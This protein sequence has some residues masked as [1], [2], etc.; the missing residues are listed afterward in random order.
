VIKLIEVSSI[1]KAQLT[2][3][4]LPSSDDNTPASQLIY[5]VYV[6]EQADFIPEPSLLKAELTG[7]VN[8]QIKGLKAGQDY[9]VLI[10]ATDKDG[11]QSYSNLL[12]G[13][14]IAINA[15]RTNS[16][17]HELGISNSVRNTGD[18]LV[19]RNNGGILRKIGKTGNTTPAALNEIFSDLSLATTIKLQDIPE[20][21]NTTQ[22]KLSAR[23][24]NTTSSITWQESG[25]TLKESIINSAISN[26]A[27]STING[28]LRTIN[29]QYG[30]IIA[31]SYAS[32]QAGIAFNLTAQLNA[33]HDKNTLLGGYQHIEFCRAELVSFTHKKAA[34]NNLPKPSS[35][36]SRGAVNNAGF[37]DK[38]SLSLNWNP[39]TA[40]I[41]LAGLPYIATIKAYFDVVGDNCNGDN[42]FGTWEDTPST[43]IPVYVIQGTPNS[44]A[45]NTKLSFKGDFKVDDSI[46]YD[47]QPELIINATLNR[48]S[49]ASADL[50][51]KADLSFANQL[52]INA[53]AA[54][55][56]SQ[57]L[58]VIPDKTFVKVF[59]AGNVPIVVSGTFKMNAQLDGNISGKANL[60]KLLQLNLPNTQFGLQYRNGV[61]SE[62][63]NIKANYVFNISGDGNANADMTLTL[64]PDL[65]ISFYDAAT[66]RLIAKPYAYA[67]AGMQGILRYLD[68]NGTALTDLNYWFTD[69]QAGGG[70]TA[71]LYAGLH[72]FDY[73]IASYPANVTINQT[74]KFKQITVFNK[75]PFIK[76]PT[77]TATVNNTAPL[78]TGDSRV[79][80]VT[81]KATNYVAP[82][83]NNALVKFKQWTTPKIISSVKT[84]QLT[85][86]N[87]TNDGNYWFNYKN[88]GTYKVRLLGYSDLGWFVQQMTETTITLTDK[89]KDGMIDQWEARYGVSDPQADD[90]ND[91]I[92]NLIE[93]NKGTFPNIKDDSCSNIAIGQHCYG[94]IIFYID[95][96]GQHGLV[97]AP[98]DFKNVAGAY[99]DNLGYSYI[100]W[101]SSCGWQ[102]NPAINDWY[103]TGVACPYLGVTDTAMGTGQSNTSKI[104][105]AQ[106]A[107]IY[108]AKLCDDLVLN[109]HDDWFLPSRD[110]LNTMYINIGQSGNNIGG[111]VS[112][113]YWNSSERDYD[114][115]WTQYF[116]NGSQ[117]GDNKYVPLLVRAVRAF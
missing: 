9:Y 21:L 81:G 113:A 69:L 10:T 32:A 37:Y 13:K 31:P 103:D 109:N 106:G 17:V 66:G 75:T 25:L 88:V 28:D 115:S 7:A 96:T 39:S 55:H 77:L 105:V 87:A 2:I 58:K 41:D 92:T 34:L 100:P 80:Q 102:Y 43:T 1:N 73:N 12:A 53:T 62:V 111:F 50:I 42:T 6:S 93:F 5:R 86:V 4:W 61:W 52:T 82:L 35:T 47:I 33:V 38:G 78:L 8:T 104:V 51:A 27:K 110:E 29:G 76:L 117:Y 94:G 98:E 19:S 65:Q 26:K 72:I 23:H 112:Y 56:I 70:M 49:L 30:A 90:D 63:S 101:N 11:N 20:Q 68:T 71:Q 54:G 67:Q 108:A 83:I 45:K 57:L 44:S 84:A 97:A 46:S 116:F 18:Y 64:I 24:S 85:N 22:Q 3:S 114:Y 74:D 60:Q 59:M 99:S 89:D 48:F 91:G 95:N 14:T 36:Y 15:K 40:N 107:G 79:M 16:R